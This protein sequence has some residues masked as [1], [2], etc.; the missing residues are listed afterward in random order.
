MSTLCNSVSTYYNTNLNTKIDSYNRLAQRIGFQLGAPVLK[1]E[2]TQDIVYENISIA[3]E[4]FTKFAGT[5][6]EYLIFDSR[7][8]DHFAGVKLDTLFTITPLMS[9]L[10]ANFDF[11]MDN[12]RKV[13]DVFSVEQGTTT[14]TN[15]LFTIEQTLAQ[16]TYFNYALGNYGFDLV[17]W[18]ITK[19]YLK[20]REKTLSQYYYFYFDPRTQ[21]LRLLPD[22]SVQTVSSRW[23]GL[24]GCYVERQLKYIVME[25][26]V[27]QYAL[28][29]TKI[30]MG[31]IRGKYAGQ[32]LF[33][34][35][36]VNYNDMLSQGLAEK[37]K[38]ETALFTKSTA[39][40]GDAEPPLFFVG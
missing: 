17:S 32:S 28:A 9:A 33:G 13:V 31:Q 3:C 10:S 26:W 15:T 14:G 39:G 18:H 24:I 37:E 11:N 34:G 40:F 19:E 35:G 25:P 4:L 6:E 22:P 21:Y 7:L 20:V 30:T 5:T 36:T 27:Q 12:Y 1:L 2:V 23:F 38:L 16:Q 8:Y 29:L